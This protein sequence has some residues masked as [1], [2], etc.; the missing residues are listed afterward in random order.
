MS[1]SDSCLQTLTDTGQRQAVTLECTDLPML[2]FQKDAWSPLPLP[3]WQPWGACLLK[4]QKPAEAW[5][6]WCFATQTNMP[7]IQEFLLAIPFIRTS[8]VSEFSCG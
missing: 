7:H 1:E 4:A 6:R 2:P 5:K 8:I 3:I